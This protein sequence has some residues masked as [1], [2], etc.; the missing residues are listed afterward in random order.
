MWKQRSKK[1]KNPRQAFT[2]KGTQRH[3]ETHKSGRYRGVGGRLGRMGRGRD[4]R[5]RTPEPEFQR[6]PSISSQ[7]RKKISDKNAERKPRVCAAHSCC[8]R[9]LN[10]S[11]QLIVR[12]TPSLPLSDAVR[13]RRSTVIR[14]PGSGIYLSSRRWLSHSLSITPSERFWTGEGG[15]KPA[16][17]LLP[18][19]RAFTS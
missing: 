12:F 7:V 5:L 17:R 13:A 1:K 9:N 2:H 10:A 11:H 4:S 15:V 16:V 14:V 19:V 8:S 3:S 18:S 6:A